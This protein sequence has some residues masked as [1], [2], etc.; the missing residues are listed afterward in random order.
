MSNSSR[1]GH[2]GARRT[3]WGWAPPNP[4]GALVAP[5]TNFLLLYILAYPENIQEHHKTIF[6]LPQPSVPVRSYLVAFSGAP[7]E[8]ESIMEGFYINTIA[9]LMISTPNGAVGE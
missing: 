2:E 1:G 6:P 9:S 3:L 5:L 4:R 7:L 8:G